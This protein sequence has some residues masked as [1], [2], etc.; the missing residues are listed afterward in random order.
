MHLPNMQKACTRPS[1]STRGLLLK[2]FTVSRAGVTIKFFSRQ[3]LRVS[4]HQG[5]NL[6][7]QFC[8][9]SKLLGRSR[10]F[11]SPKVSRC[12]QSPTGYPA[13]M[14]SA[15]WPWPLPNVVAALTSVT[16]LPFKKRTFARKRWCPCFGGLS[17]LSL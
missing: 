12:E 2:K 5:Q 15:G 13:G 8:S 14:L 16:N 7:P 6:L 11:S 3:E 9:L 17:Y 1:I 4:C 10:A